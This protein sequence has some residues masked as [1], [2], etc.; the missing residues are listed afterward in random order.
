MTNGKTRK[1]EQIRG[2]YNILWDRV[3]YNRHLRRPHCAGVVAAER[4]A[5]QY[6]HNELVYDDELEECI[7]LTK[8]RT[9][10]WVLGMEWD[11]AGDT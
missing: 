1:A 3:W 7:V 8:F 6:G 4:L 5:K 9:L 11:E 10:G 2:E